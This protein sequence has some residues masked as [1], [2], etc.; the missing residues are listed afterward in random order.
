MRYEKQEAECFEGFAPIVARWD[1]SGKTIMKLYELGTVACNNNVLTCVKV[2]DRR[3]LMVVF[4]SGRISFLDFGMDVRQKFV[5]ASKVLMARFDETRIIHHSGGK[6]TARENIIIGDFLREHLPKRYAVGRGE[7]VTPE[8]YVSGQ[9]D[10][11][12][13]DE[14][15]CPS[16]FLDEGHSVFPIESVYAAISVRSTLKSDD[17]E[18]A[19]KNIVSLKTIVPSGTVRHENN[20]GSSWGMQH[21]VPVTGVLAFSEQRS[22]E[23]ISEQVKKL[24]GEISDIRLRPDFIAVID[25]G[26]IGPRTS[27]RGPYNKYNLPSDQGLLVNVRKTGRHTLLR[28]Y[29]QITTE[30]DRIDLS[31]F[32]LRFYDEMPRLVGEFRVRNADSFI[33]PPTDDSAGRARRLNELAIQE[34]VKNAVL[35]TVRDVDEHQLGTLAQPNRSQSELSQPIYEY[36]PNKLPPLSPE[37]IDLSTPGGATIKSAFFSPVFI[38]IDGKDYAVDVSSFS[39]KHFEDNPD[40]TIDELFST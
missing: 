39:D 23:A 18:I 5:A 7:V 3:T 13:F 19:Y 16:F 30:L 40:L 2:A 38:E 33:Q 15:R 22:L 20:S 17:L 34:I 31:P 36:N 8:N 14:F 1:Q 35:V 27:L 21:P 25:K 32:D 6:G 26:I 29:M 9:L 37:A 28:L 12:I 10:V 24:D 11:I 4:R